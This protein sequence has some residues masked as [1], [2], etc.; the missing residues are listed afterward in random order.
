MRLE[1]PFNECKGQ[2]TEAIK[3]YLWREQD[4]LIS[5]DR[6]RL[7]TVSLQSN[8]IAL[9]VLNAEES[10]ESAGSRALSQ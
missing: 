4:I 2:I 1:I 10:E 9:E 8:H 5:P 7:V 3:D 6:I